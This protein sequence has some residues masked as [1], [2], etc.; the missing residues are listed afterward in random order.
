[1]SGL[2]ERKAASSAFMTV[3]DKQFARRALLMV[4]VTT[5]P[6]AEEETRTRFEGSEDGARWFCTC[7]SR[8]LAMSLSIDDPGKLAG[9]VPKSN[10]KSKIFDFGDLFRF[11]LIFFSIFFLISF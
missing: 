11:D 9:R 4:I 6:S 2:M 1:M 7:A 5:R 8:L 3:V 10:Q